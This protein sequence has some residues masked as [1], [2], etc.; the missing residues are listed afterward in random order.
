M[1]SAKV[2]IDATYEGD[3][4]A[5]AGAEMV[6]GRESVAQ[7]NESD[8]G[9]RPASLH[10]AVDPFW[11]DG[12]VIPHVSNKPLVAVGEADARM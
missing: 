11:P 12:S 7:Y 1:L 9:R 5:V 2:W 3:L 10:Y 8:A 6:W 4:A